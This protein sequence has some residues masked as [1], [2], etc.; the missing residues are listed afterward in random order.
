MILWDENEA[1]GNFKM[2]LNLMQ[3][4]NLPFTHIPQPFSQRPLMNRMLQI[5]AF[6][7]QLADLLCAMLQDFSVEK[8]S[9]RID[10]LA[11]LIRPHVQAD[12]KKFYSNSQFEQNLTQDLSTPGGPQGPFE[13]A[14]LSSFITARRAALLGQL[15]PF[16]CAVT[17]VAQAEPDTRVLFP[18]PCNQYLNLVLPELPAGV[19]YQVRITDL[20]GREIMPAFESSGKTNRIETGGLPSGTY[21][22]RVYGDR[23]WQWCSVFS[24]V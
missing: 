1:F 18:N 22:V 4:K 10:S 21:V 13:I 9:L 23:G 12:T 2:G 11:S 5:A 7:Q 19:V 14:G 20:A 8:M 15:A 16:G 17:G 6:K 3:I 24:K